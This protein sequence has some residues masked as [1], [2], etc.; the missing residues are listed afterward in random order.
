MPFQARDDLHHC[1][2]WRVILGQPMP[3]QTKLENSL[4]CWTQT[5]LL[6]HWTQIFNDTTSQ[7]TPCQAKP[8]HAKPNH[9]MPSQKI[10]GIYKKTE[11][12]YLGVLHAMPRHAKQE[13]LIVM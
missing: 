7:T 11:V 6:G 5:I 12:D 4:D 8:R 13:E 2:G 3:N 10:T 1:D 9:A